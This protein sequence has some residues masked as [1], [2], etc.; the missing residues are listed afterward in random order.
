MKKHSRTV[1]AL[2]LSFILAAG[3]GFS[4]SLVRAWSKKDHAAEI[5][6]VAFSPDGRLLGS[7]GA[8]G[9]VCLYV[10]ANGALTAKLAGP[11]AGITCLAFSPD[12]QSVAGGAADKTIRVWSTLTG[13][14]LKRITGPKDA[15]W[16]ISFSPDGKLIAAGIRDG[17]ILLF[18]PQAGNQVRAFV[19]GNDEGVRN[20]AF[21]PD[22][23]LLVTGGFEKAVR[24]WD[25]ATGTL[26]EKR[27]SA[28]VEGISVAPDGKT[29]SLAEEGDIVIRALPSG[30][31][32]KTIPTN[33]GRNLFSLCYSPDGKTIATCGSSELVCLWDVAM[34]KMT[35]QDLQGEGINEVAF[36]PD[37]KLLASGGYDNEL[38]VLRVQ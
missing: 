24:I 27:K 16:G 37:G 34:G 28:G 12:S 22:G 23:K 6:S 13:M 29:V 38:V 35:A 11:A 33:T 4:A 36:S 21:S 19:T 10:A 17:A 8:D 9:V 25:V 7:A 3:A 1:C 32:V 18:D 31:I 14:E 2:A 20:V 5:N 26:L 30:K 15:V